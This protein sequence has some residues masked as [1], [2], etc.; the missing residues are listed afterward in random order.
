M[1]TNSFPQEQPHTLRLLFGVC[2]NKSINTIAV[3]RIYPIEH[4]AN[5]APS[6]MIVASSTL[7]RTGIVFASERRT[8]VILSSVR[9]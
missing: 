8:R 4:N 2:N 3:Y 5:Q 1:Q 6:L 7:P 9:C